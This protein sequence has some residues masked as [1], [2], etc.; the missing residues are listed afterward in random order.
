MKKYNK[1]EKLEELEGL[2]EKHL[3]TAITIYQNLS[4]QEL[5]KTPSNGGWCIAQ[6]LE[7][8]NR[9]GDYYIPNIKSAL[10]SIADIPDNTILNS[11]WFGN[12]FVNTM[13][14]KTGTKK[15]KA[16]KAY[17]P[18]DIEDPHEVVAKFIRQQE[19]LLIS[20]RK[21]FVLDV[22]AAK[23]PVSISKWIR[24]SVGDTFRFLIAHD[25]RHFQQAER[26]RK[27]IG[28]SIVSAEVKKCDELF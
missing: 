26:C 2:V 19:D 7:H 20:V 4:A 18:D 21:A 8:L 6:C 23:I 24:L 1:L 17:I 14:P 25:E 3:D 9:Y 28:V 5:L 15:Y 22:N 12:Y 11:S 13:D 10:V 16:F 27:D